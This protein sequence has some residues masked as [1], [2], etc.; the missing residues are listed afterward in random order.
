MIKRM[1]VNRIKKYKTLYENPLMLP[2][3]PKQI[4][5]DAFSE[6]DNS[7]HSNVRR[8]Q[9]QRQ[10]D[11]EVDLYRALESLELK[12]KIVVLHNFKFSKSQAFLYSNPE[13]STE[14]EQDFVVLLRDYVIVLIEV[15][16]PV[17]IGNNSFKRNFAESRKQLSRAKS[18]IMNIC[19]KLEIDQSAISVLQF[20]AFPKDERAKVVNFKSFQ[21]LAASSD[22]AVNNIIFQDDV[23]DFSSWW[24]NNVTN[25]F[26][27][28]ISMASARRSASKIH[29]LTSSLLGIWC[30][31]QNDV[32]DIEICSL[33]HAVKEID[34]AVKSAEITQRKLAPL[35]KC[36]K[37]SPEIFKTHFGVEFL[38]KAQESVFID[39]MIAQFII[40][41]AGSGKTLLLLGKIIE[42][43]ERNPALKLKF[44]IITGTY[45]LAELSVTLEKAGLKTCTSHFAVRSEALE[46]KVNKN[47]N[48]A[49]HESEGNGYDI[50]ILHHH[51]LT[52]PTFWPTHMNTK[53]MAKNILTYLI[54]SKFNLFVDDFHN[55]LDRILSNLKSSKILRGFSK[56]L[57]RIIVSAMRNR[58]NNNTES[59]DTRYFW[60]VY[61]HGQMTVSKMKDSR[62]ELNLETA[63]F[64]RMNTYVRDFE[65]ALENAKNND[66]AKCPVFR[67]LTKNL[68]NTV[69]ISRCLEKVYIDHSRFLINSLST[70]VGDIFDHLELPKLYPQT[71]HFIHGPKPLFYLVECSDNQ[72]K[73]ETALILDIVGEL[74]QDGKLCP[75]DIAIVT[76]SYSTYVT[77]SGSVMDKVLLLKLHNYEGVTVR[78]TEDKDSIQATEWKAVI[79]ITDLV[80]SNAMYQNQPSYMLDLPPILRSKGNFS[81]E[82]YLDA[83]SIL[84]T[85]VK[86]SYSPLYVAMSRA[87]VYLVVIGRLGNFER[88]KFVEYQTFSNMMYGTPLPKLPDDVDRFRPATVQGSHS[89]V[90][91]GEYEYYKKENFVYVTVPD[92]PSH[93]LLPRLSKCTPHFD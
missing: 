62:L 1:Y 24:N 50:F 89:M 83:K 9:A 52:D 79:H 44:L 92:S 38:T 69:D 75:Q 27:A 43:F 40:G 13:V 5:V 53:D 93:A 59:K 25:L 45:D 18:L 47:F 54:S 61:D 7:D 20:T 30:A 46:L 56:D 6:E 85:L 28:Q 48:Q 23:K 77:E 37:K 65:K 34:D 41:P 35:S 81:P 17:D 86:L 16:S 11:A 68:R 58:L 29:C 31:D 12:E 26:K 67:L 73:V 21:K 3:A 32:Y 51:A 60:L 91:K 14:G 80:V 39:N 4:F 88:K 76:D 57:L 90:D 8:Q 15:K 87:R 66:T 2:R 33:G 82:K 71:G 55:A 64:R 84:E 63:F 74:L 36:V 19:A 49:F 22:L 42:I 10:Y 78:I 72:V 70:S